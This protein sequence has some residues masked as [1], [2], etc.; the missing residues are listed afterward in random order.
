MNTATTTNDRPFAQAK[1][2]H[3]GHA[4]LIHAIHQDVDAWRRSTDMDIP[5][6]REEAVQAIAREYNLTI[7]QASKLFIQ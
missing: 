2:R 5:E 3:G 6:S 4:N 1:A 7:R